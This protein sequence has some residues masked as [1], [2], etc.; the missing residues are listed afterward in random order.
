[1]PRSRDRF[2]RLI[3]ELIA[4]AALLNDLAAKN[5]RAAA[6]IDAGAED[7][8]DYAGLGYTIHNLYNAMEAYFLRVAKFFE[9]ELEPGAWHRD[10]VRRMTLEIEGVRPRLLDRDVAAIVDEMRAFRH[11]FRN[12]YGGRLDAERVRLLQ[13]R[14]PEAVAGFLAAHSGFVERLRAVAAGLVE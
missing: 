11:I 9:N 12:L 14:V 1:M 3:A 4:D 2:E 8:L 5:K 13:G 7:E 6:R 10:L